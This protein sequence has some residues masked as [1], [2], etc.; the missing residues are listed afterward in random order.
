MERTLGRVATGLA[1][2]AVVVFGVLTT[3]VREEPVFVDTAI[4][5]NTVA[6]SDVLCPA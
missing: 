1:G 2:S 4:V 3:P 5:R 6:G